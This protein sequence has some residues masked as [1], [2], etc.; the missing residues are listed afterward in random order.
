[1]VILVYE[2]LNHSKFIAVEWK[3][4]SVSH[5]NTLRL[6]HCFKHKLLITLKLLVQI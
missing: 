5:K 6:L 2:I 4:K 1:M 3:K